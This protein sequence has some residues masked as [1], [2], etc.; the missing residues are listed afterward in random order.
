MTMAVSKA[1]EEG[2]TAAVCASTGNTS[3]SA[4]AYAARAG[5]ASCAVV[6]PEGAIA[7]RQARPGPDLRRPR[8]RRSRAA[9][10]TP[11][12]R[13]ASSCERR[14]LAL[15][16]NAQPLPPGGA[17]DG[18]LRDLSRSSA[19]RPTGSALPGRQ[20][21]QHH[22]LLEGVRGVAGPGGSA[23]PRC[24]PAR[25]AGAAPLLTRRPVDRPETVATAIRIGSPARLD[26]AL[27]ALAAPRATCRGARPGRSWPRSGGCARRRACSASRPRRHR[28][29]ALLQAPRRACS[30]PGSRVVCVL[31]GHGLKDPDTAGQEGAEI[32]RCPP[33][34]ERLEQ[35]AFAPEPALA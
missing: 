32:V 3:A 18:R 11:C 19:A 22:R 27:A 7:R 31:T 29:P 13:C 14:P 23:P 28:W 5:H 33:E 10:T 1:L 30:A 20:R 4:A 25:R 9:S 35:L 15:F 21:R 34:V 16:N 17:E 24:W 2:A 6:L 26:E 8:D 12:G